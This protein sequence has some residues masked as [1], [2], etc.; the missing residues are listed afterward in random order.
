[1]PGL[2][3]C[4]PAALVALLSTLAAL[5]ALAVLADGPL[6]RN[7]VAACAPTAA[8]LA[9]AAAQA[10]AQSELTVFAGGDIQFDGEPG[11]VLAERG[12]DYTFALVKPF[13]D[14]ADLRLANLECTISDRGAPLAGKPYTFRAEPAVLA[15]LQGSFDVL[16]FANNHS[17]DYGVE[18]FLDTLERAE[19]AG[20]ALAG[21]GRNRTEAL[22]PVVIEANGL[23][24]AVLGYTTLFAVPGRWGP[25]WI[26]DEHRPGVGLADANIALPAVTRAKEEADIVVVMVHWGIEY[27]D[28]V[29]EQSRLARAL[30]DAGADLVV[31]C[32]PHIAQTFE[33]YRGHLIAYSLGNFA[34]QPGRPEARD[35]LAISA[36]LAPDGRLVSAQ[37]VPLRYDSGRPRPADRAEAAK[38]LGRI[39]E[40]IHG[41]EVVREGETIILTP[42]S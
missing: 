17:F 5:A 14:H 31:G 18:A 29:S 33:I 24:V 1:M 37:V 15:A 13:L 22:R 32:H 11:R 42:R 40:K 2:T 26:P 23:R 16:S 41:A 35:A 9:P 7:A 10:D 20:L 30:I 6:S 39:G 12:P 28:V 8:V 27:E 3:V 36:R 34:M 25:L 21:A 4:R 19:R 38:L